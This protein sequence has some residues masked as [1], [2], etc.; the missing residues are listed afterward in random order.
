MAKQIDKV[1]LKNFVTKIS[2]HIDDENWF[3]YRAVPQQIKSKQIV[4]QF[5]QKY[6]NMREYATKR[7]IK[8]KKL[9]KNIAE[10]KK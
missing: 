7:N 4:F 2:T 8:Q 5:M 3:P 1:E 6:E 9:L 10:N